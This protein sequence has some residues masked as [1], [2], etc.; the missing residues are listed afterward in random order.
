MTDSQ[1]FAV[2][3]RAIRARATFP[4]SAKSMVAPVRLAC[5]H[6]LMKI[7]DYRPL[8]THTRY[9]HWRTLCT[10]PNIPWKGSDR[11]F[12]RLLGEVLLRL[13]I[14]TLRS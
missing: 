6:A 1:S 14:D 9:A 10:F 12:I 13:H 8:E 5:R 4:I 3:S 7:S 11:V 2:Q